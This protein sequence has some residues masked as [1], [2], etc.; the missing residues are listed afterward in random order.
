MKTP[1]FISKI[2]NAWNVFASSDRL[3]YKIGYELLGSNYGYS[4]PGRSL[5][6]PKSERSIISAIITRIAVDC[7]QISIKHVELDKNDRYLKTIKSNLNYCLNTEANIDQTGRAFLF[8]LYLSL[9]DNGSV[10]LVPIVTHGDPYRTEESYDIE[11]MR[12]GIINAWFPEHVQVSVYNEKKGIRENII[13]RKDIVAIVENPFYAIMNEPNSTLQRLVRKLNLLD[14]IDEQTNSGKLNLLIQLPYIV[15]TTARKDQAEN[16]R[17]EIEDQLVN[18]KYGIAYTDGTEKVTQLN[19]PLD[20]NLMA[21]IEYLTSMLYS[22]LQITPEILN[23]TADEKT[24]LNYNNR[25][26][27][28]IVAAAVDEMKRKFLS[29]TAREDLES[30]MYFRDPFKLVP[31][32]NIA[33]IADKFTRNEIMTSNE[34]RQIIG[35]LPSDDPNA[36]ILRNKNL[37]EPAG[38]YYPVENQMTPET[39]SSAPTEFINPFLNSGNTQEENQNG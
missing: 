39:S 24:M 17:K 36:D 19:R 9:L 34:I 14:V 38:G 23:G 2:K 26:I 11:N 20:N 13:V 27:E 32:N 30:I 1:S 7:A 37:S 29:K 22:Q 8:D 28:P 3:E 4:Q 33:E 21:Q 16:R 18:S 31:I 10:A 35:L 15:K 12:V 5:L 6:T 25:I